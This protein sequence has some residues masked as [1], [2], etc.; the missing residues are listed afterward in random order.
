MQTNYGGR[1]EA[2]DQCVEK[3]SRRIDESK[4]H[5]YETVNKHYSEFVNALSFTENI[6]AEVDGLVSD[7]ETIDSQ[8]SV[9][10]FYYS[11]TTL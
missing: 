8:V 11:Q 3:I 9:Q 7:L 1:R 2:L 10:Q 4:A 5:I 6:Q